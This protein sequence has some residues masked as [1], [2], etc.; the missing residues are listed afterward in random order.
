[1]DSDAGQNTILTAETMHRFAVKTVLVPT[2]TNVWTDNFYF[3]V[4]THKHTAAYAHTNTA[5]L[6]VL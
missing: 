2:F 5:K 1:M 6:D 4:S 3:K